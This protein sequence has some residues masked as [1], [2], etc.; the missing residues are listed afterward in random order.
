[1]SNMV[2]ITV[3]TDDNNIIQ[4]KDALI[5]WLLMH[6]GDYLVFSEMALMCKDCNKIFDLETFEEE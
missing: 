3:T 6:E 5:K 2:T 4:T 1:M